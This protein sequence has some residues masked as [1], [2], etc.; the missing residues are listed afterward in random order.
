MLQP[1]V[2]TESK[3]AFQGLTTAEV[4][5]SRNKFGANVQ[6]DGARGGFFIALLNVV[7]EPM[8]ILLAVA[9]AVYFITGNIGDGIIMVS[10]IVLVSAISVYQDYRSSNAI[11]A[12]K[13]LSQPHSK[14]IRNGQTVEINSD[15]IVIGDY[16]IVEEGALI[17]AD[18]IIEQSN[19]FSVNESILTGESLSVFKSVDD[20]ENKV[21]QGSSVAGG[22]AI[23]TVTQIGFNTKL[24][25]IGKS[26]I[27]IAQ[28][29]TPL[30]IQIS[31][32]V[33]KMA[34]AGLIVFLIVWGINYFQSKDIFDSLLKALTLAMSILPEEI[35]VAFTTFMA[36]GSWRLM[37]MGVIVKQTKTV[38][39]L[40]SAT[41]ICVDKTG[42]IT[43]NK[44]MLVKLYVPAS[45]KITDS[46]GDLTPEEKNLVRT[47]MWASEP[48][49][50]DPME[51]ALHKKY[52]DLFTA[53]ERPQ[54]KMI[55][56]Y[57]LDGRPPMM[58]H[59]FENTSATRI[60]AAKGAPEAIISV[61]KL[62]E[63]EKN[64]ITAALQQLTVLGYRVL[65]VA[66]TDHQGNSF[67]KEQQQ[68]NFQ[69][70]GL[71]AFYDPPKKNIQSVFEGFD[72]AGIAVKIITGDNEATTRTIAKQ[73]AFK[74]TEKSFNGEM[75]NSMTDEELQKSVKQV[76]IFT[77]MFPDAKL[78]VIEALK[79]NNEVVAM[80]GDGVN[81]GPALKS[82]HIGIAMGKKGTEIAKQASSII[83]TDDDLAKM[84]DAVAMGRKIYSNL[85][86]AIQYII[87]IH[88]PIILTVFIPLALG[89]VY[90][91]IFTPVHVIFLELIMGPTC[92]II[93]ENEPIEKNLMVEKPRLFTS[94]FF[95]WRE[96][97]TSIVQGLVIAA[98]TLFIYQ[99]AVLQGSN[100]DVTRTMVFLT[101][102]SANIFLTLVNRSFYY[103]LLTT[104]RYK[105]NLVP[106]IILI[107]VVLMTLL[108]FID[109][110]QKLFQFEKLTAMQAIQGICTG[111]VSVTWFEVVKYFKRRKSVET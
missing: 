103:S 83:L 56:E 44:M 79:R 82:A 51:T 11:A 40:G 20:K 5:T 66:E 48:I 1:E 63:T 53:D 87:S 96:L 86:K 49:P 35:P 84:V 13:T 42:T 10:A 60:I 45:D 80:T 52:A 39:S 72:K 89:W 101:L 94:T 105:N 67:P 76:N 25:E 24:G 6:E 38:E 95:N 85:K 15:E 26:I 3:R 46:G 109:P 70:K 9:S 4:I 99:Y 29:Q 7:K 81:D 64:K 73:V 27:S 92:S 107:T 97:T 33:K 47:A 14:V 2:M 90:P 74:G 17:P 62:T 32:F 22:L 111:F 108:L 8:F 104:S 12:L 98:G 58:T 78:K 54:Y 37:K 77:R 88:I 69:F 36:L 43:E 31:N 65:G 71:V 59:I 34:I 91:N 57:P 102:I 16:M 50:F 18:G 41:V 28:E 110:L 100:E 30:Q 21:Y 61:S 19:D 68:F 93:Y 55:H 106:L 23:C 75:V